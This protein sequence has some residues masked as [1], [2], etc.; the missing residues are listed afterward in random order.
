M[1][2]AARRDDWLPGWAPY[3]TFGVITAFL[4]REF[5]ISNGMLFG[6]DVA[7]L[8]YFA[9]HFYAEMVRGQGIFPQW[10]PYVFGGLPF[11]DAM[12]GDIF[13]PTTVLKFIMPAHRAMG[14]KLVLHIFLAGTFTY[15]WL[16]HLR[17]SR[18]VAAWGGIAYMLAPVMVTLIYP[19]HDGKLFVSA[20]TPL[21]LWATDWAI[22]RG[23]V[24]RFATLA[25]VVAMLIFT[26]HMQLA[27]FATWAIVVL[28]VYRLLEQRRS[29][30]SIQMALGRLGG[31][32]LAGVAGALLIG[33]VQ[34]WTP[35]RYLT[36]YSQRVEKT[37]EAEE[38]RGYAYST[39]WS[40]H[41][42]EAFS[43]V[44][45]EFVGANIQTRE[46]VV[47]TYWGRNLFKLNHEYGGLIPLLLLPLAFFSRRRR[48]EAWLFT[49]LAI[50]SLIYALGAT[51]PLFYLFY[52]LVPGV[53]LFRAPSSIMFVFAIAVI[54]VAALGLDGM[55]ESEN[56]QEREAKSRKAALYLWGASGLFLLLGVLASAGVLTELWTSVLYRDIAPNKVAALQSNLPNIQQGIWLTFLLSA[57]VA[58]AWQLYSRGAVPRA[59]W[60]GVVALLAFLDP[61]R[62]D[63][64]YITM[65]DPRQIYSRDDVTDFLIRQREQSGEPFRVFSVSQGALYSNNQFAFYGIEELTGH[66]GN[67][68]GR[69]MDLVDF[70][71]HAAGAIRI[72]QLLNVRYLVSGSPIQAPGLVE[73]FRGQ[74]AIVYQLVTA[75]PRAFLV[76]RYE[77]TPDTLTI[78]RLLSRDFNLAQSVTLDRD[79]P[80]QPDPESGGRVR[81]LE[82]G[83]NQQTLE[84][85]AGGPA[86]LVVSNNYYPS[87]HVEIDG[88]PAELL[89]ADHTLRGVAVPAGTHQVRFYYRSPLYRAA[90]WTTLLS[91]LA[92]AGL[93]S[94]PLIRRRGRPARPAAAGADA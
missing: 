49:G 86:I 89:R 55:E 53:K 79:P 52:Y 1:T 32:A 37:V 27:Y 50:A 67:E 8:G 17:V 18:P 43:L 63:P 31:F 22:T 75:F 83:I 35:V 7:A 13:Y 46:G 28:A 11:V 88:E 47:N 33:A 91:S 73:A 78:A 3:V 70:Q 41:P 29:G 66:H 16:R 94:V 62:V 80:I 60:I 26:A 84:I 25:V 71:R 72:L 6:T 51:T 44:V 9:R 87:W 54:T 90:L 20:L 12:H 38:E 74:R 61:L 14:W 59:A 45:P 42:E 23:G 82:D 77:T 92:V 21:A 30:G 19:G 15:T 5:I 69:Y 65:A 40:L 81:W 57:I 34:L 48:G 76:G 10:N 4:F 2:N 36:K 68:I 85:E 64:Q 58:G 24:G 93:V 56:P 39:S